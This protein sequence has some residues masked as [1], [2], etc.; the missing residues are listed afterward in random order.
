[1]VARIREHLREDS[2]IALVVVMGL[3]ALISMVAVGGYAVASQSM[4]STT[5]LTT[6]TKAFQAAS[7]GLDRELATFS[8]SAFAVGQNAYTKTGT[9]PDPA[10]PISYVLSV[11][12]DPLVPYRFSIICTGTAGTETARVRQDFYYLDLW[13]VNI[14]QGSAPG[15]PPGSAADFNGSAMVVGPFFVGSGEFNSNLEFVGGPLFARGDVTFKGGVDFVPQPVGTK[16]VI[17]AGGAC[18]TTDS[19]VVI[20][21]SCPD[22][23]LPWV[24]PNYLD[25]VLQAATVQS[26]D[27]IRGDGTPATVVTEVTSVGNAAT[28]TGTRPPGAAT[29][30]YKVING[31]LNL[32]GASASF[33]KVT[34]TAGVAT[35]WDDFAYDTTTDTLYVE[36]VV[37]VKGNVTIGAGVQNYRGN[38]IIVSEGNT[39]LNT[40]TVFQPA[41]GSAG[42]VDLTPENALALVANNIYLQ[43]GTFEGIVFSNGTFEVGQGC[44]FHG[45]VHADAITNP[46]PPKAEIWM[47][48]NLNITAIPEGVPGTSTDPRGSNYGGGVVI[49][50]TWSRVQ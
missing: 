32:T 46:G 18:S 37:Y 38:G 11:G 12:R 10:G 34:K 29:G 42:P 21:Q 43:S 36:G 31:A 25:L 22:L 30:P 50:G 7:S 4:H 17:Y 6:E 2:G 13:S 20:Q 5:R 9:I 1:M 19:D 16:Y 45:A 39:Y 27:N 47:E 49:P 8:E 41:G 35:S 3:I 14:A 26:S 44:I 28:Y 15:S 23:D 33:G 48:T 40:G 24:E